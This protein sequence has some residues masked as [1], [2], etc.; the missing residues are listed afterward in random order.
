[1]KGRGKMFS[2]P[3]ASK[4]ISVILV[5][6]LA[7]GM[8]YAF[9]LTATADNL[10]S[11][12]DICDYTITIQNVGLSHYRDGEGEEKLFDG[13]IPTTEDLDDAVE[14]AIAEGADESLRAGSNG[15]LDG[16]PFHRYRCL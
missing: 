8:M 6:C 3:K 2:F 1:M 12:T 7:A 16:N 9:T 10:Y 13:I 11:V 4:V 15:R 5:L 14:Q